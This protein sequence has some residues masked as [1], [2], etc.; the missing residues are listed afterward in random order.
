MTADSVYKQELVALA[1]ELPVRSRWTYDAR[2]PFTIAVAFQTHEDH[3]VRWVFA[4]DLLV[5]GLTGSAGIGDV[6]MRPKRTDGRTMLQMEIE[7]PEGHAVLE[8]EREQVQLFLEATFGFV[9]LGQES[10]YFD[11]DGLIDEI[12][13]V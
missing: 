3:W 7:S 4:R 10:D 1:D 8:L 13:N 5:N 2:E 12:T 6:R 11:V 9:P